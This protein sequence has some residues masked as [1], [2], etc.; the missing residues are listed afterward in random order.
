MNVSLTVFPGYGTV[1]IAAADTI[2]PALSILASTANTTSTAT[3]LLTSLNGISRPICS[4]SHAIESPCSESGVAKRCSINSCPF[5]ITPDFPNGSYALSAV[6]QI[7]TGSSCAE[8]NS[9]E[10]TRGRLHIQSFQ[11]PTRLTMAEA[12]TQGS[13]IGTI[14]I[15]TLGVLLLL[16]S[17]VWDN[18]A[19]IQVRHGCTCVRGFHDNKWRDRVLF[20]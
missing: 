14:V 15:A 19:C 4:S 8:T 17:L 13:G 18:D 12:T 5:Q 9:I 2:V 10:T 3:F 11:D 6:Y 16:V 20:A 7:C 1:L